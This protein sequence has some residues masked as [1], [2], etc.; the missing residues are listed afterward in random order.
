MNRTTDLLQNNRYEELWSV[1]DN[2]YQ[3]MQTNTTLAVQRDKL[4]Q[5][6]AE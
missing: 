2:H 6:F 1:R 5:K 3:V 4:R